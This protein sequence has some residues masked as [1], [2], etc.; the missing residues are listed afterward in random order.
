MVCT[1]DW[2]EH[3]YVAQAMTC[4]HKKTVV[5]STRVSVKKYFCF[6]NIA[7]DWHQGLPVSG[8]E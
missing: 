2:H 7:R 8:N 5:V 4:E 1:I 3:I 6:T